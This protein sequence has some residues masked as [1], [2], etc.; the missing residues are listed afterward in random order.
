MAWPMILNRDGLEEINDRT[1]TKPKQ[2]E[3]PTVVE[4]KSQV[5]R[6]VLSNRKLENSIPTII[7]V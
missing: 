5:D 4:S 7:L 3:T 1:Y 6:V 2:A